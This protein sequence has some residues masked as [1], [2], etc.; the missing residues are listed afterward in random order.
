MTES[1]NNQRRRPSQARGLRA[2]NRSRNGENQ[3]NQRQNNQ[4][5]RAQQPANRHRKNDNPKSN[6]AKPGQRRKP[7]RPR[8]PHNKLDSELDFRLS[9]PSSLQQQTHNH[10]DEVLFSQTHANGH[11]NRKGKPVRNGQHWTPSDGGIYIHELRG[12]DW[13]REDQARYA[14]KQIALENAERRQADHERRRNGD[15]STSRPQSSRPRPPQR[16]TRNGTSTPARATDARTNTQANEATTAESAAAPEAPIVHNSADPIVAETSTSVKTDTKPDTTAN[17]PAATDTLSD[18]AETKKAAPAA[19][20]TTE[21]N[22]VSTTES[23]PKPKAPAKAKAAPKKDTA[24]KPKPVR[25]ATAKKKVARVRKPAAAK[26]TAKKEND[27][28]E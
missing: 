16:N 23:T 11:G 3:N 17:N 15:A 8:T 9:R 24:E 26:T 5:S 27:S 10:Q 19:K 13:Y 18:V 2:R 1:P 4:Q 28:P 7:A 22:T 14:A 20:D 25:K 6:G 12:S 21:V